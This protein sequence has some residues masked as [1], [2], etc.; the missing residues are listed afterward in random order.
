MTTKTT[1]ISYILAE[2]FSKHLSS[3]NYTEQFQNIKRNEEK[4]ILN[5]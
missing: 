3:T 1:D 2:K 5:F 4:Q